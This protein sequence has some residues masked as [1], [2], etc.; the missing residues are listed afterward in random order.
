LS[1]GDKC[2][3]SVTFTPVAAGKS[4]GTLGISNNLTGSPQTV[5]LRGTGLVASV[6][7]GDPAPEHPKDV[8]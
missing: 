3:I 4:T 2:A 6:D 7:P 8:Q 5:A 1:A